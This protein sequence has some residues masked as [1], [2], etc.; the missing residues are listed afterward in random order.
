[1]KNHFFVSFKLSMHMNMFYYNNNDDQ[2]VEFCGIIFFRHDEDIKLLL[3]ENELRYGDFGIKVQGEENHD[4]VFQKIVSK[5]FPDNLNDITIDKKHII[6][7][8]KHRYLIKFQKMNIRLDI[9]N[10]KWI[11]QNIFFKKLLKI[12]K[13]ALHLRANEIYSMFNVLS[14]DKLVQSF[15][16]RI[17]RK[18]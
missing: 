15:T 5:Y 1:M 2:P 11:S 18:I 3:F 9:K 12:R 13:L 6:Y 14:Q 4:V 17:V 16:K 7:L 8:P 10:A